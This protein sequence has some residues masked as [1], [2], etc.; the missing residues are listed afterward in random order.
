MA[1]K[2]QGPYSN[3]LD[4]HVTDKFLKGLL[5]LETNVLSGTLPAQTITAEMA[6]MHF[7]RDKG[8]IDYPV[9]G[10]GLGLSRAGEA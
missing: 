5:D 1:G 9:N 2:I 7:E 8:T 6:V 4:R 3:I 10:G